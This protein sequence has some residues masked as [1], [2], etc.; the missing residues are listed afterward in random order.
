MVLH[1]APTVPGG[2]WLGSDRGAP[3]HFILSRRN[4]TWENCRVWLPEAA[5]R[6]G[7]DQAGRT[8]SK[9]T[10]EVFQ[11]HIDRT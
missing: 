1:R 2:Q 4:C 9:R 8:E 10:G 5:C 3:L 6:G 11:E 7:R